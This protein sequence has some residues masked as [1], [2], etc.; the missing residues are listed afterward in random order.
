MIP[1]LL[2][3]PAEYPQIEHRRFAIEITLLLH[4]KTAHFLHCGSFVVSDW[5]DNKKRMIIT[6]CPLYFSAKKI[7]RY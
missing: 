1:P 7:Y 2:S 6:I 4:G 5:A 3:N